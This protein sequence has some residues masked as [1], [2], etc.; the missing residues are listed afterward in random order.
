[1]NNAKKNANGANDK[2]CD[3]ILLHFIQ[4]FLQ[5]LIFFC[6]FIF[7]FVSYS[8]LRSSRSRHFSFLP[9]YVYLFFSLID[10]SL[11]AYRL[12]RLWKS[13]W[14]QKLI[15]LQLFIV[16]WMWLLLLLV[17]GFQSEQTKSNWI[18]IW[19][20]FINLSY[21]KFQKLHEA[22]LKWKICC[23]TL[24]SK[25]DAVNQ[26]LR[27]VSRIGW[28]G[29]MQSITRIEHTAY[30]ILIACLWLGSM[31]GK[32]LASKFALFYFNNNHIYYE[33]QVDS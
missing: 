33:I 16:I 13:N 5:Q 24:F 4:F 2:M 1:M 26:A 31:C 12:L 7:C 20:D 9:A 30:E 23:W 10:L 3:K 28:I 15:R 22:L 19:N 18:S 27:C 17:V 29:D 8:K 11:S 21:M 6:L 32:L 25:I 14:R